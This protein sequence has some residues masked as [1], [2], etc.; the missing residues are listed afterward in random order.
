[1]MENRPGLLHQ[2]QARFHT[3]VFIGGARLTILQFYMLIIV[4]HNV[5]AQTVRKGEGLIERALEIIAGLP[6]IDTRP[7]RWRCT[8]VG[9]DAIVVGQIVNRQTRKTRLSSQ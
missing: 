4:I 1:M 3:L 9:R 7:I 6:Q 2:F 5:Q 8:P